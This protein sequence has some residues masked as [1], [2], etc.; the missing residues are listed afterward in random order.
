MS[1]EKKKI[2]AYGEVSEDGVPM[3]FSKDNFIKKVGKMFNGKK[4]LWT[5]EEDNIVSNDQL[6]FYKGVLL[7]MMVNHLIE[8]G[9]ES[10]DTKKLCIHLRRKLLFK[11]ELN[12]VSGEYENQ[13]LSLKK[14]DKE[15]DKKMMSEYWEKVYHWSSEELGLVLPDPDPEKKK[16]WNKN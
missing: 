13:E 10:Y 6:A 16:R 5:V 11:V 15:V 3:M 9:V 2:Y 12:P 1:I 14:A 8:A 7:P 4:I